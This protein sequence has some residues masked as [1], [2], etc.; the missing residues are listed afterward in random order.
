MMLIIVDFDFEK[1]VSVVVIT[2]YTRHIKENS[3][4]RHIDIS[5]MNHQELEYE[6]V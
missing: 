3:A 1:L 2:S 6:L 4:R 5:A